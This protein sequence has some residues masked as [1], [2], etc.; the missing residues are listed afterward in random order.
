MLTLGIL[1]GDSK[2]TRIM[3]ILNTSP[4]SFFKKSI[5]TSPTA[6][7]EHVQ[8]MDDEGADLIDIGGMSTA[9]YLNTLISESSEK[10]R[11]SKAIK[12]VQKVTNLPISIDTPRSS[13]AKM[14]LD[15]GA[16][17]INDVTGLLYDPKMKKIISDFDSSV[18]L[19]AYSPSPIRGKNLVLK[20]SCILKKSVA[21]ANNA[22]I[23]TKKI[24]LDP[25]IGFF[26]Q[27]GFGKF[28]TKI[29]SNW[30]KRDIQI[31][32]NLD[33]IKQGF[34][35]LVSVSNKS[36]IGNLLNNSEL[37]YRLAGSLAFELLAT[38]RGANIIR[39][40]NV[41]E[42]RSVIKFVK[43]PLRHTKAYNAF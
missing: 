25:C 40:H 29:N 37:N 7:S 10:E 11:I 41:H 27:K 15:M 18:I 22:G 33:S 31:I 17:I 39:T 38:M 34:P 5:K 30:V 3:G 20:T 28:F 21:L 4:E 32:N 36:F 2:P 13:V 23:D 42:T 24:V 8:K 16:E 26:R 14:A 35:I 12:L 43:K 9:P 19:G 1:V 6:I